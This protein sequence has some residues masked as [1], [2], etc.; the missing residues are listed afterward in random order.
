MQIGGNVL[1]GIFDDLARTGEINPARTLWNIGIGFVQGS[2]GSGI[3]DGLLSKLGIEGCSFGNHLIKTFLGGFIDTGID[4]VGS[5]LSEQDFDLKSSLIQNLFF[6]GLDAFI[7]DPVDAVT[8]IYVIQATDFLLA[9]VPFA[10]KL[11]RSYYSTNNTVS[12]LGLGWKFPYA[13][14]IYRDTRD[15][16]HTRVHL[17]TITGHS[18]CYEEQDGRWVNQSKG[19]SRFL[20]EVQEAEITGQERYV[21]T[22]V[23]DHTLSVYDARGLLQSVEY[24]NQQ[25]LSFAYGEEGLERIVTP[26]GNVLQVECRG[27]RIL[28]ITDEIGRRTQYRYEG[29]LLVDV[30]HTDEGITHYEYDENGHI[31]SV[32]DQNGSCY[33]ENEYDVKGRVTRQNFSSGVYQTFTYDDIHHRNTIITAKRARRR[34]MNTITGF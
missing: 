30:V 5:A 4:G 34:S 9:S 10:L 15:V 13:S 24:P 22:D 23:V 31:S 11:E 27:G 26:L 18:V 33:L 16:E 32:T 14:R 1:D 21:L 2:T 20:M 25:R 3:R 29:D 12:V 19:A 17:E 28:Q 6:N 7:S 8:G